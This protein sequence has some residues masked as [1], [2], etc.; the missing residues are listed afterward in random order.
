ME[1]ESLVKYASMCVHCY[2]S[3]AR[4]NGNVIVMNIKLQRKYCFRY[5]VWIVVIIVICSVAEYK[6]LFQIRTNERQFSAD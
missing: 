3:L 2:S 5:F 6:L 1:T 4:R